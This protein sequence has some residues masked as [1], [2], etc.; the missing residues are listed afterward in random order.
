MS[1][2]TLTQ[3]E[4][5]KL[6]SMLKKTLQQQVSF[7]TKGE[8]VQFHVE[9]DTKR[10]LFVI[11]LFR[12]KINHQKYNLGARIHKN[13]ISLLELHI[14]RNGVHTNPDGEK[15][16]GSHWHIYTEEHG[17]RQAFPIDIDDD[18]FVETTIMFLEK[19]NVI[20]KPDVLCQIA[21]NE[22]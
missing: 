13:G 14:N 3:A 2:A 11:S 4:A 22:E 16:K 17:R 9:G 7:P 12:G 20:E 10:D 6:L 21:M 18:L 15:I 19:F 5:E 8:D 1:V